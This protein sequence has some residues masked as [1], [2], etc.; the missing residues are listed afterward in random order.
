MS[1]ITCKSYQFRLRPT[2]KQAKA[3]QFQLN[4]C[5][6]LYNQL[7]E[8]RKLSY[9][10]LEVNLNKYQQSMFLPELKTERPS[11]NLVHSQVLQ[12]VVDRLDKAF[13]SF[14]RRCKNGET[15]GFPRF[16]SLYRYQS[17]CYPQSG[18]SV[19][20]NELKLSKVGSIRLKLHRPVS[21]IIKTCT[22]RKT[23]SDTWFVCL[24]CEVEALTL[25]PNDSSI[26]IDVGLENFAVLTNGETISNPR[27]FKKEEKILAKAQAK[28]S[29]KEKGSLER[30]KCG[31]IV[32]KIHE[33][34]GNKRKD[35][36]H[37]ESRKIV[38]NYHY[39]F[40]EDLNIKKMIEGA[41]LAK[42]IIDASL[43]PVSSIPNLQSGRCWSR[44]LDW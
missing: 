33:R 40:V 3:L 24:A 28:F 9:E 6:W 30:K 36:C 34:I 39:I 10:E 13:S 42:N 22:I 4:E 2:K 35:F 37:K 27:F 21:G 25:Q 11:L 12:N 18:F 31:K 15:P 32:A 19:V 20:G 26:G 43:R 23:A 16:R 7:L 1:M 38:D 5:R 17:M 44:H 8:Q 14:F 41:F 29:K